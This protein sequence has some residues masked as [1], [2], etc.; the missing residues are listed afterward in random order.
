MLQKKLSSH[1]LCL[2][3]KCNIQLYL[4]KEV[5]FLKEEEEKECRNFSTWDAFVKPSSTAPFSE[6]LKKPMMITKSGK[7]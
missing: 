2:K 3:K 7:K 6:R 1:S 4:F 5:S